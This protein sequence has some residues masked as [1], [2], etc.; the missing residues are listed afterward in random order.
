MLTQI[1]ATI[2]SMSKIGAI[3]PQLDAAWATRYP[4]FNGQFFIGSYIVPANKKTLITSISAHME[5]SNIAMTN[6]MGGFPLG[7]AYLKLNGT[8]KMEYRMQWAGG[9]F[10]AITSD[11]S[12]GYNWRSISNL[13][14]MSFSAGDVITIE[15]SPTVSAGLIPQ[16][17]YAGQMFWKKSDGQ[18]DIY[19]FDQIL[20]LGTANQQICSYTVPAGGA[21][22]QHMGIE[23]ISADFMMGVLQ[24]NL[25]G[26]NILTMPCYSSAMMSRPVPTTIPLSAGIRLGEG[27]EISV[28]GDF[29]HALG[30]KVQV[31]IS[32]TE[33]AYGGG[34]H[35]YTF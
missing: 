23:G 20:T 25:D 31:L 10:N 1:S 15:I 24:I 6:A 30:Q 8:I 16:V 13:K 22:L 3:I 28:Y 21:K 14:D 27:Q 35:S 4:M 11:T 33:V 2:D 19:K 26:G 32:G 12:F 9:T 18:R 5:Y 17:R 34:E 7:I 29:T